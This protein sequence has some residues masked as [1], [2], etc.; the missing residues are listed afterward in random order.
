MSD[1]MEIDAGDEMATRI[2]AVGEAVFRAAEELKLAALAAVNGGR[3]WVEEREGGGAS[4]REFLPDLM[5]GGDPFHAPA[6]A[7]R[8][9]DGAADEPVTI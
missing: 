1:M 7:P 6:A 9:Y 3:A 4:F 5:E 2:V 8:A